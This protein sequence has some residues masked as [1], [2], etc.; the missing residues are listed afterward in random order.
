VPLFG[1]TDGEVIRD[2]SPV[3]RMI[4][5]LMKGRSES[6]VY[7]E[8]V[9]DL[10]KTLPFLARWNEK[11]EQKLTLFHLVL[12][13]IARALYARP[14][15]NRFVSGGRIYQRKGV[16]LSFAAKKKFADDAPLA[17]IKLEM[18][19]AEPLEETVRRIHASI[20]EGRSDV[21]RTV[22]KEVRWI[23]KAPHFLVRLMLAFF[24]WLDKW[25]LAPGAMLKSDPMYASAFLANLG[26]V[27]IDR[28]WHHLY[29]YGTVSVFAALGV[30]RKDLVVG[31]TGQPEVRDQVSI[32]Y[33]YDERI[34]DGFYAAASLKLVSEFLEDPE[35]AT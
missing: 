35:R 20:G 28:A 25:N 13:A 10:T 23:L 29:E 12:V 24:I 21:E 5:Y 31:A 26:S 34:N 33:S 2:L 14:G 11:H 6:V 15:I 17:T 18:K 7:F 27:G 32:R 22:D 3:R 1:R 8:Q 16:Q 19:E 30:V 4:P 9:I